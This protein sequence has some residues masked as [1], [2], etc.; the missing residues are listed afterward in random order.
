MET[1]LFDFAYIPDWYGQLEELEG[2]VLPEP[3][4]FKRP[5][6]ETKNQDTP[7]LE[8]YIHIIFRKQSID[9]NSAEKKAEAARYFHIENE[10]ACFHTGLYTERYKAIYAF[11]DRNKRRDSMLD[12]Y[13][14]GAVREGTHQFALGGRGADALTPGFLCA[15]GEPEHFGKREVGSQEAVPVGRDRDGEQA[16]PRIP[17]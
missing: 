1:D 16:H 14:R 2:M 4:Q 8:R 9:Y 5:S 15:G 17:V 13:F 12:W 3:W 6:I 7:I 11:F 10:C